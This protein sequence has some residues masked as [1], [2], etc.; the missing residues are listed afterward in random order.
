MARPSPK[1]F[2]DVFAVFLRHHKH[3]RARRTDAL[4]TH[5]HDHDTALAGCDVRIEYP[6]GHRQEE[7]GS[8]H[9]LQLAGFAECLVHCDLSGY[10]RRR[11]G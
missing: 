2:L 9:N 10:H 4:T 3:A 7:R 8:N 5:H 11:R 6:V 1:S